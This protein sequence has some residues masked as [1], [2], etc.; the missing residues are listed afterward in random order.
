MGSVLVGPLSAAR[1]GAL[2]TEFVNC[3]HEFT[4][5]ADSAIADIGRLRRLPVPETPLMWTS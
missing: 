3:L 2:I 1:A 5:P 4:R